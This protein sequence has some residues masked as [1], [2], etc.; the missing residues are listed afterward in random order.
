M[1]GVFCYKKKWDMEIRKSKRISDVFAMKVCNLNRGAQDFLTKNPF[2]F[3]NQDK[4]KG[5]VLANQNH[6]LT[7]GEVQFFFKTYYIPGVDCLVIISPQG[8][9][10]QAK[11]LA[12]S[13]PTKRL[14]LISMEP[15]TALKRFPHI[16][17][18]GNRNGSRNENI[19]D[20]A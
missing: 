5:L 3:I 9:T 19:K 11:E 13:H 18:W 17:N 12:S 15:D 14:H 20:N 4:L 1:M 8:I 2:I 7:L 10:Q 16:L 6:P